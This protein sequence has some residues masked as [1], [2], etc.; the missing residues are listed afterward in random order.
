MT[1]HLATAYWPGFS[2]DGTRLATSGRDGSVRLWD[3][4]T[5]APLLTLTTKPEWLFRT[6]FSP[7]GRWLAVTGTSQVR[8]YYAPRTED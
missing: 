6:I 3:A 2:P 7:D 1:G 5:G 4:A 8:L